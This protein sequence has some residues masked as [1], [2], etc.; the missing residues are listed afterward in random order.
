MSSR[1]YRIRVR[2][3][4]DTADD[5]TISSVPGDPNHDIISPPTGDGQTLDQITSAVDVGEYAIV[6]GD[7]SGTRPVTAKLVDAPNRW[8][9]LSRLAYIETKTSAGGAWTVLRAGWLTGLTQINSTAWE[10]RVGEAQR[11]ERETTI[12]EF[13]SDEF[14]VGTSIIGGPVRGGVGGPDRGAWRF[15]VASLNGQLVELDF[16]TGMFPVE[17]SGYKRATSDVPAWVFLRLYD[18]ARPFRY[19]VSGNPFGAAGAVPGFW[20]PDLRV[21]VQSVATGAH[22]GDFTPVSTLSRRIV[23]ILP[24]VYTRSGRLR[25]VWDTAV[26][27]PQPTVGTLLDVYVTPQV[28][29]P[30]FPLHWTGHPI[31]AVTAHYTVAG[32]A[33]DAAS[34]AAVK[35]ALGPIQFERRITASTT[36]AAEV[37]R[38]GAVFG[39]SRRV[40][41][42]GAYEFF[43]TRRRGAAAPAV[44]ITTADLRDADAP[45]FELV[46]SSIVNQLTVLAQDVVPWQTANEDTPDDGRPWDDRETVEREYT[47]NPERPSN[48]LDPTEQ[49]RYGVH[50]VT[51]TIPGTI[52]GQGPIGR[53]LQRARGLLS[54]KGEDIRFPFADALARELFGMGL[55]GAPEGTLHCL[56]TVASVAVGDEVVVSLPWNIDP[57]TVPAVRGGSRVMRVL[58]ATPVPGGVDLRV[59]DAGRSGV[60]ATGPTIT[61]AADPDRPRTSVVVTITNAVALAAAGVEVRL[62]WATGASAPLGNGA[63]AAQV[64]PATA[65]TVA[66]PA[67][68]SGT[69]VWVRAQ[70]IDPDEIPSA[71]SAW[72]SLDLTD[73]PAP[74]ALALTPVVGNGTAI[75][76]AWTVGDA[77][78]RTL[79]AVQAAGDAA[80]RVVTILPAGSTRYRVTELV[81]A[82][83]HTVTVE[84]LDDPP[85]LGRSA[86]ASTT[87]TTLGLPTLSAPDA[88]A[89]FAGSYDEG[90]FTVPVEGGTY[91]LDVT[92]TVLPSSTEFE[93]AVETAVGSGVAGSYTRVAM[94]ASSDS[95]RTRYVATAPSDGLRRYLRARHRV[96]TAVSAYTT[97]LSVDPWGRTAAPVGPRAKEEYVEL[98]GGVWTKTFAARASDV[99]GLALDPEARTRDTAGDRPVVRGYQFGQGRNGDVIT[100]SPVYQSPP[101]I[102]LFPNTAV[103]H[104]PR[105]KYNTTG[106]GTGTDAYQSAKPTLWDL[107]ARNVSASGFTI[108]ARL[109]QPDAI[110]ATQQHNFPANTLVAVGQ[111]AEVTL[112][113]APANNDQYAAQFTASVSGTANSGTVNITLTVA[114]DTWDNATSLWT[115]RVASSGYTHSEHATDPS[116]GP[117]DYTDWLTAI[118]SGL[119]SAD[120][121][122]VR[123]K[124]LSV[125][126]DGT[127][128][129]TI[130]AHTGTAP[131]TAPGVQYTTSAAADKYAS[132]TPPSDASAMVKWGAGEVSA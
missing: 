26:H 81:A 59:R 12:Y 116:P 21:R 46:E 73:I 91:G 69:V 128:S 16:R 14:P 78:L 19:P 129:A 96:G 51:I 122:R 72:A 74:T 108:R 3:A 121:I 104:D 65:T 103:V 27:G 115:E 125:I 132:M 62:E 94:V 127:G 58:Q 52:A 131:Y 39:F 31:D 61:L 54:G 28:V 105:P 29:A 98:I 57:T 23:T 41:S 118:V 53:V 13:L 63:T 99:Q 106:D 89:V 92:A 45:T 83:L 24:T 40:N 112:A 126:G 66:L 111:T 34:A 70:S 30:E 17:E 7:P 20:Y 120:K 4:D 85:L 50:G 71:F 93:E 124:S 90:G 80:A 84:H 8:A 1:Y 75:D 114:V 15:G 100:F 109:R 123:Y 95:D 9:L 67:V 101:P 37:D 10:L 6:V 42:A 68:D 110:V 36:L 76:A 55:R 79:V 33:Y 97:A 88:P 43:L 130:T 119:D 107:V 18:A 32:I 22:L 11:T 64:D 117:S 38:L 35:T 113:N 47:I 48:P 86:V 82:T 25:I 60:T 2:N 87:A 49:D 44:T 5:L 77:A 102:D 56:T